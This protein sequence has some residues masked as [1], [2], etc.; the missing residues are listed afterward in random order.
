MIPP[1][2]SPLPFGRR[3]SLKRS[4]EVSGAGRT[5][6]PALPLRQSASPWTLT[7]N[8]VQG[9][10]SLG[11]TQSPIAVLTDLPALAS[12]G[13]LTAA[14]RLESGVL[15]APVERPRYAAVK[16]GG[17]TSGR[18]RTMTLSSTPTRLAPGRARAWTGVIRIH[19]LASAR[20]LFSL[21]PS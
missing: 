20:L 10:R 5:H 16:A 8:S 18:L 19:T 9:F 14:L 4:L 2:S 17:A 21:E 6:R 3:P 7:E 1:F 12:R 15:P 13:A 11:A